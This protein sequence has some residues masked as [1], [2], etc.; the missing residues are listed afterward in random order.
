LCSSIIAQSLSQNSA[1]ALGF[2]GPLHPKKYV[3]WP[4]FYD[5]D[6]LIQILN[7]KPRLSQ[8]SDDTY[9]TKYPF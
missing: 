5:E 3:T 7:P 4:I 1:L 6:E 2:K 9:N 8:I